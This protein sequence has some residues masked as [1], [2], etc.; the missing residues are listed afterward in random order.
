MVLKILGGFDIDGGCG[1][2]VEVLASSDC[3]ITSGVELFA[4]TKSYKS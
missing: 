2:R 1:S 3:A 4:T